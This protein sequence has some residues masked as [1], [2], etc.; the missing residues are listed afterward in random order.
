MFLCTPRRSESKLRRTPE[1]GNKQLAHEGHLL[2]Q[3][4][5]E[6]EEKVVVHCDLFQPN[7]AVEVHHLFELL[8]CEIQSTPIHVLIT[9]HPAE[10]CFYADGSA[11]RTLYDPL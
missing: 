10:R 2:G 6:F 4:V 8:A 7:V 11:A 1:V 9:R 5:I 3:P